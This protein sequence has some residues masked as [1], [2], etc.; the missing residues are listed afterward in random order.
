MPYQ[1]IKSTKFN[2]I[3]TR[4]YIP[5]NL[6]FPVKETVSVKLNDFEL[7]EMLNFTALDFQIFLFFW[8]SKIWNINTK[9]IKNNQNVEKYSLGNKTGV[10]KELFNPKVFKKIF[11]ISRLHKYSVHAIYDA[12]TFYNHNKLDSAYHDTYKIKNVITAIEILNYV[13]Y[14]HYLL[15]GKQNGHIHH[16]KN[17]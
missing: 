13:G 15:I 17:N 3:I 5:L 16:I 9:K 12:I 8:E 1:L 14:E 2:P 10:I 6:N 11:A 7:T 4:K